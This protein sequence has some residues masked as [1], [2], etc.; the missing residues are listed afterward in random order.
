M[1]Y[2]TNR[3]LSQ[4]PASGS[5]VFRERRADRIS[6]PA[7]I[8]SRARPRLSRSS[9]QPVRPIRYS[10]H[11]VVTCRFAPETVIRVGQS[12]FVVGVGVA[13]VLALFLPHADKGFGGVASRLRKRLGPPS[14]FEDTARFIDMVEL[15]DVPLS[16]VPIFPGRQGLGCSLL[17][18]DGRGLPHCSR[19]KIATSI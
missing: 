18:A 16:P 17:F 9:G 15:E 2:S 10:L 14:L 1:A 5:Q 8:W 3:S 13:Q 6:F 12:L 7:D 11:G 4:T 19:Q